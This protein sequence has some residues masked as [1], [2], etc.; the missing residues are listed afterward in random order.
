MKKRL[1]TLLKF[2]ITIGAVYFVYSQIDTGAMV[3]LLSKLKAEWL[4]LAI[5]LFAASKLIAA[6]RLNLHF[7][8]RDLVLSPTL[9]IKLYLVG[10]FYNLFLPGGIGGDGYKVYWLNRTYSTSVKALLGAALWDRLS[11]ITVLAFISLIGVVWKIPL[12]TPWPYFTGFAILLTFPLY[13]LAQRRWVPDLSHIF[14]FTTLL[15]ILSQGLVVASVVSLLVSLG[16]PSGIPSYVILFLMAAIIANAPVSLGGLGPRELISILGA[17]HLGLE[18]DTAVALSLL[19]YF[20][21]MLVSFGGVYFVFF[22]EA[23][24]S[25]SDKTEQKS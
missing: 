13:Y 22:P 7:R 11:G 10:M 21:S 20:M 5:V 12:P 4:L 8:A 23:L 25:G 24:H 17:N 9:N 1:F 14:I 2:V 18:M 19:Y 15:S 16:T 3:V 6:H